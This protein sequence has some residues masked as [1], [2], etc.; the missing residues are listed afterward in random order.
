M[1]ISCKSFSLSVYTIDAKAFLFLTLTFA[2][3]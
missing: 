1:K 3:T 2:L